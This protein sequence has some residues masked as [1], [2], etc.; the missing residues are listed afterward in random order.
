MA[1]LTKD[2]ILAARDFDVVRI[3]VPEWGGEVCLRPLSCREVERFQDELASRRINDD[4]FKLVDLRASLL[5]K[6]ICDEDGRPI[7]TDTDMEALGEKNNAVMDRLF[8][9]AREIS[10]IT[11]TVEDEEKN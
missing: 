7:F 6:A 3:D 5:A 4:R 11:A 10:G 8:S 1:I 2:A 9:K